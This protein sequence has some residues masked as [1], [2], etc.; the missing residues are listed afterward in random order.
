MER[1]SSPDVCEY[2]SVG[3]NFILDSR[4]FSVEKIQSLDSDFYLLSEK[5]PQMGY[6]NFC[7]WKNPIPGFCEVFSE[8]KSQSLDCR[9]I[10]SVEKISSQWS[11]HFLNAKKSS[12]RPGVFEFFFLWEIV[13]DLGYNF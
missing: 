9:I 5:I 3:T 4:I 7:Y 11:V 6:A 2:F 12:D 10:V 8:D 1:K 13:S